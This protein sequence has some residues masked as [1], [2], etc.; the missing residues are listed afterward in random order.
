LSKLIEHL[1]N[2]KTDL[3]LEFKNFVLSRDFTW[4]YYPSSITD[5]DDLKSNV[6][7]YNHTFLIRPEFTENKIPTPNC[8]YLNIVSRLFLEILEFNN[9]KINYFLRINANC[10]HP[11][12]KIV[13]TVPHI[14]HQFPEH[15]NAIIYLTNAGGSTVVQDEIFNPKEDDVIVFGGEMHNIQTPEKD[16]RIVLVATF[17]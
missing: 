7:F 9:V 10:V 14:D 15:K 6:S 12:E 1:H 13:S 16:R 5:V 8:E 4:Y 11:L 3:Y 2:P 17:V